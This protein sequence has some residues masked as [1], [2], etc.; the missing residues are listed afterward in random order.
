MDETKNQLKKLSVTADYTKL[1]FNRIANN[2]DV[3]QQELS[4]RME[5]LY[6]RDKEEVASLSEKVTKLN[7]DLEE[8]GQNLATFKDRSEEQFK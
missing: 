4:V 2:H 5:R 1:H 8:M 3:A 7:G 6:L